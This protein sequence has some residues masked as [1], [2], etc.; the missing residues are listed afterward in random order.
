MENL[1]PILIAENIVFLVVICIFLYL[2]QRT[3]T[4]LAIIFIIE[5]LIANI[6]SFKGYQSVF[7]I[8]L[9]FL[10]FLLLIV[11]GRPFLPK[12]HITM[13]ARITKIVTF[14]ALPIGLLLIILS[15]IAVIFF[16]R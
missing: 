13:E 16:R 9:P 6:L 7:L 8:I 3:Y 12:P 1:L 11:L 14:I 4:I 2:R 15:I 10:S 5:L